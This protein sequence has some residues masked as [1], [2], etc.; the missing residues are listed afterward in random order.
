MAPGYEHLRG[1]ED[2]IRALVEL[3]REYPSVRRAVVKLE[4]GFSGEGNAIFS[5]NDAPDCA[6]LA[7]WVRSA[8]P[9]C[10]RCVAAGEGWEA[11]SSEFARMGGIVEAFVDSIET[12][13]PSAQCR[14]DP[15]GATQIISTHD[16]VLG[17]AS[18]QVYLGCT[19]P[20][21]PRAARSCEC[22]APRVSRARRRGSRRTLRHRLHLDESAERMEPLR[23][24]DKPPERRDRT[25]I[26]RFNSS[27]MAPTILPPGSIT[28]ARTT[29]LLRRVR[30]FVRPR[31][32]C[33]H[34]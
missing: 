22:S 10:I 3:K 31:V 6:A 33:A 5:Y 17:G 14:I 12:R 9:R 30:Q 4:E 20:P 24:R 32:R 21:N 26:W 34:A 18:G 8:L 28:A 15:L 27:P 7:P 11:Y 19:F 29:V 16:Q 25:R 23:D 1:D 2:M 13:S